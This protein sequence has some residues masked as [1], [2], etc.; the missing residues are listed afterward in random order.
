MT[1]LVLIA[2]A[3]LTLSLARRGTPVPVMLVLL[4]GLLAVGTVDALSWVVHPLAAL[5]LGWFSSIAFVPKRRRNLAEIG[6][7]LGLIFTLTLLGASWL[8]HP[9]AALSLAVIS[10]VAF[11]AWSRNAA[12]LAGALLVIA[13]CAAL[14]AGWVVYPLG[15]LGIGWFA[16]VL[17]SGELFRQPAPRTRTREAPL[18]AGAT[19]AA[20]PAPDDAH[21]L[22]PETF[23]SREKE[24]VPAGHHA[25]KAGRR[26]ERRARRES[27]VPA[28]PAPSAP[29]SVTG[30][31]ESLIAANR[32]RLP[33]TILAQL[34]VLVTD[35]REAF[36][37]QQQ[38]GL[39]DVES[40]VLLRQIATDYAPSAIR[41][42]LRLPASLADVTPLQEGK[43]GLA[44]LTEQLGLLQEATRDILTN[45]A[46][47][48]GQEILTHQ[49]FLREKFRKT[50]DFDV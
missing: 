11:H 2:L 17:F 20:L 14:G 3:L 18:G 8:V 19:P 10:S 25:G 23:V 38:H 40:G 21:L 27:R 9:V 24:A 42:Y 35:L 34:Q 46:H 32:D 5:T 49:R 41:A 28:T 13:A 30:D 4:A 45:A 48:R 37:H 29:P 31:L 33:H 16:T 15:A 50:T 1:P 44:L 26:A 22:D 12:V 47:A 36:A 7:A 43:T 39:P 6:T